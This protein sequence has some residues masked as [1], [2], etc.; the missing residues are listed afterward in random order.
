M[1]DWLTGADAGWDRHGATPPPALPAEVVAA[2]RD[3]YVAAYEQLSGKS[4][5]DWTG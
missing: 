1:R 5:D 3:R 2:T 4:F